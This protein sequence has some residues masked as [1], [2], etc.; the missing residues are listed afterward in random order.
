MRE[1]RISEQ[2][3]PCGAQV[4]CFIRQGEVYCLLTADGW[5]RSKVRCAKHAGEPAPEVLA[6]TESQ[7]EIATGRSD[8]ASHGVRDLVPLPVPA[9]FSS[10]EHLAEAAERDV[11]MAQA[12]ERDD[13]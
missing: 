3:Y 5:K 9:G 2:V 8:T 12:G 10:V 13:E 4:G 6:G 7:G 1:W 11:K